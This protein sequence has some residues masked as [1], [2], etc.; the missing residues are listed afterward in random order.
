MKNF[1]PPRFRCGLSL[2]ANGV[3][4]H[5][6]QRGGPFICRQNDHYGI[7]LSVSHGHLDW[8]L[9][10]GR[11]LVIAESVPEG[12]RLVFYSI[13]MASLTKRD[14]FDDELRYPPKCFILGIPT[15]HSL[16]RTSPS[17]PMLD[18]FA[19]LGNGMTVYLARCEY[20]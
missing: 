16:I 18:E 11:S 19:K 8:K 7:R 13:V 20:F 12:E 10:N 6:S 2:S 14:T 3:S 9:N 15:L 1:V 4:E 5:P 17:D